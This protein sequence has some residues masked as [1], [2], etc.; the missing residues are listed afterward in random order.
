MI[1]ARRLVLSLV[2]VLG[3]LVLIGTA[4]DVAHA[5]PDPVK[6]AKRAES[7][8][9]ANLLMLFVA[10]VILGVG[11]GAATA[12]LRVV[13]PGVATRG[14]A[15]VRRLGF[16][17][18][19]LTGVLPL[20]GTGLIG[21]AVE[22][23]GSP[24]AGTVFLVAIAIPLFLAMLAGAM[25]ALPYLGARLLKDG[26]EAGVLKQALVGGAVIGLSG[27]TWVIPP[28]GGFLTFVVTGWLVGAGIGTV[29]PP[30]VPA[31]A[32]E[33]QQTG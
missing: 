16:A 1:R 12:T 29:F 25:A 26:E 10:V 6:T 18:L 2:L 21:M 31:T 19:L 33:P 17:R 4:A 20:I 13:L 27:A 24:A 9:L 28:L 3:A 11:T 30:G 14:D 22:K 32:P 7:E 15:S 23:T 8:D 5:A